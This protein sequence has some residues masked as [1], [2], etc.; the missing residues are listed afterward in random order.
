MMIVLK[1]VLI[2]VVLPAFLA[3]II[4]LVTTL[5]RRRNEPTRNFDWGLPLAIGCGYLAGHAGIAWPS[6]DVTDRIPWLVLGAVALG[7][8]DAAWPSP[9]WARWENGLVFAGAVLLV[10]L[11]PAIQETWGT[12]ETNRWMAALGVGILLSWGNLERLASKSQGAAFAVPLLAFAGGAAAFLLLS[13]SMVL[14]RLGG[15]LAAALLGAWITS[16]RGSP[17]SLARGAIP[18]VV[19]LLA[20]LILE[21]HVYA[22]AAPVGVGL[23]CASPL[24][25]WVT[26]IRAIRNLLP[27]QTGLIGAVVV[28]I[29]IG[30]AM[31]LALAADLSSEY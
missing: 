16:W 24:L 1:S 19:T 29:P 30:V 12:P 9:L 28:L 5:I 13:G 6:N 11:G 15:A 27:W 10:M 23:V 2:G 20:A 8:L 3:A 25:I 17:I 7:I 14:G 18:V 31:G 21:G 22:Q 4:H 26:R